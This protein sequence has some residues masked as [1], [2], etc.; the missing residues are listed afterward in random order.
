MKRKGKRRQ[1]ANER[2]RTSEDERERE[3]RRKRGRHFAENRVV[4]RKVDERKG[5]GC[6]GGGNESREWEVA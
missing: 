1:S 3:R 6:Y 2:R 5:A 4:A